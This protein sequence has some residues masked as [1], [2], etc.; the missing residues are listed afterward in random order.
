MA[1][2]H[3]MCGLPGAGKTTLARKLER[4]E[5]A[6]RLCPD[7]WMARIVG[8]G[9]DEARRQKVELVQWEIAARALSLGI[10]VVLENGFWSRSER[11]EFRAKAAALGARSKVHFLDVPLETLLERL[12]ARN[13]ALPPD[14]FHV[15]E[16]QLRMF[17]SWFEPPGPD[18][19]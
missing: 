1:T 9:H 6:L 2:L 15:T 13:Q 11:E 18:E 16:E 7:E 12:A 14:T 4:S 10:D 5:S 8:D 19:L 17:W 3:L